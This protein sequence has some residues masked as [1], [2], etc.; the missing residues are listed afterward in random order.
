MFIANSVY[1]FMTSCSPANWKILTVSAETIRSVFTTHTASCT[2][3]TT[4]L[5]TP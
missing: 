5:M 4:N 1:K 2:I 3:I